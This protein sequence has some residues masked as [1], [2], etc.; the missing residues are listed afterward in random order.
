MAPLV[1]QQALLADGRHYK[2]YVSAA[3]HFRHWRYPSL[4][5]PQPCARCMAGA[6]RSFGD[7]MPLWAGH[8]TRVPNCAGPRRQADYAEGAFLSLLPFFGFFGLRR[9][10]PLQCR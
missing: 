10:F 4:G 8:L 3:S 5:G 6:A 2:V 7:D 9:A 1:F